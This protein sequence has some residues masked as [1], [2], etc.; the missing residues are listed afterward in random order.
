MMKLQIW[1]L[2]I[3]VAYLAICLVIGLYK[4]TRIKTLKQFA[5]GYQSLSTTILVCTIF[6]ST[7]G[8]G[9]IFGYTEKLYI[10][11][12]AFV[13]ARLFIPLFWFISAMIFSPNIEQFKDCISISQIMYKLY[14]TSW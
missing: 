14:G 7:V 11:G 2:L 5:L 10:Y 1:D 12:L 8:A 6:A 9:T 4:Y 3:V 13:I